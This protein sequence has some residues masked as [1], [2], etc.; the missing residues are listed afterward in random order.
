MGARTMSMSMLD[1][2]GWIEPWLE[3]CHAT[4]NLGSQPSH[5]ES[6]CQCLSVPVSAWQGERAARGAGGQRCDG[7][8]GYDE[9]RATNHEPRTMNR[10]APP[11]DHV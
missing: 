1:Q 9:P 11:V 10:P 6:A 4:R 7:Y 8:D 2:K 3:C 5:P